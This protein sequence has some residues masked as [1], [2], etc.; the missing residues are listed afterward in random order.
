MAGAK[1]Q[2]ELKSSQ[3]SGTSLMLTIKEQ[4]TFWSAWQRLLTGLHNLAEGAGVQV[5]DVLARSAPSTETIKERLINGH[6]ELKDML[7]HWDEV[8]TLTKTNGREQLLHENFSET[9]N[10]MFTFLS[11]HFQ[12][13]LV[14]GHQELCDAFVATLTREILGI[15]AKNSSAM[16]RALS[17]SRKFRSRR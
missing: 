13:V 14:D 10:D 1:I 16:A 5:D 17:S 15:T 12:D 2:A 9:I 3:A 6:K 11:G 8:L 7:Q 4:R